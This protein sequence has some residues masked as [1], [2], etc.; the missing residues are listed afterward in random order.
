MIGGQI[1]LT[2]RR[3]NLQWTMQFYHPEWVPLTDDIID[4]LKRTYNPN[5]F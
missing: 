1:C 5:G 2:I 4:G 3:A